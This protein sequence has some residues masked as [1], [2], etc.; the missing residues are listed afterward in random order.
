MVYKRFRTVCLIRVL[1][2]S[3]NLALF[4]YL[5]TSTDL[6]ATTGIIGLIAIYQTYA[7][8]RFVEL[9]NRN[10][11]RFLLSIEHSDFSQSFGGSLK[12]ASFDELHAAFSDVMTRFREVRASREESL[13]YLR[14][15]VQHVGVGILAYQ[16]N[17]SV[18]LFNPA[19]KKLFNLPRLRH[20][21]GLEPVCA[22]LPEK[23][24][25]IRSGQRLLATVT[26]NDELVHLS[27]HATELRQQGRTLTLVTIQNISSE[28][29][30]KEMEAW[31]NL[32]R[33]LTHEIKNSLTPIAS[34]AATVEGI[35]T[36]A[37]KESAAV[38]SSE[39]REA[40]QTIQKRAGGLQ[41]FVDAYRDLTHLPKP[42]YLTFPVRELLNRIVRL[43]QPQL[44]ER[45]ISFGSGVEPENLQLVADPQ[46][47]EQALINL[48]LN[49][50]QAVSGRDGA[51]VSISAGIDD[52]GR[53]VIRVTDNGPGIVPD[54]LEKIFV[55]FYSTRKG[56]SGIGLSLARQI[57]RR[58]NGDLSVRSAPDRQTQ[59]TMRF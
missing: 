17:G 20:L 28:L 48:V 55:P 24:T 1:A 33:V 39:V 58:H 25:A 54:A 22:G 53:A 11:Q 5:L 41:Q 19:A 7:L 12:G 35:L 40:L 3:A 49:A 42:E 50:I 46:L 23:L 18:E 37:E 38:D 15:I 9:S 10:L 30:E 4:S 21:N 44:D 14:T 43:V 29:N 56:G 36:S 16:A 31:Q 47:V 8:I 57:M 6:Y 52:R 2:L 51:A 13:H 32:I 59:F 45:H 27:I 26:L 34:L